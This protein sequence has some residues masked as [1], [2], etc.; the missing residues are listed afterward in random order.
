MEPGTSSAKFVGQQ[1]SYLFSLNSG[2]ADQMP[3]LGIHT[4]IIMLTQQHLPTKSSS[5]APKTWKHMT[6][7]N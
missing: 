1:A 3:T 2:V 6:M 7:K 5:E 4:Q